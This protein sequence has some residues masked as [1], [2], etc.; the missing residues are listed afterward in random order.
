MF[1]VYTT[2][3]IQDLDSKTNL[4]KSHIKHEPTLAV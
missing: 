3:N 1:H 2:N 4:K